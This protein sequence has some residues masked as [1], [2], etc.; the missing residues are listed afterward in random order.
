MHVCGGVQCLS[1]TVSLTPAAV[2]LHHA[3]DSRSWQHTNALITHTFACTRTGAGSVRA[4][5]AFVPTPRCLALLHLPLFDHETNLNSSENELYRKWF[6]VCSWCNYVN[7][8]IVKVN[9]ICWI[10]RWQSLDFLRL[11]CSL[12]RVIELTTSTTWSGLS[13]QRFHYQSLSIFTVRAACVMADRIWDRAAD[14]I[15]VMASI[16]KLCRPLNCAGAFRQIWV[17][18]PIS[19]V[20]SPP[21]HIRTQCQMRPNSP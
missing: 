13:H 16:F 5:D 9:W 10:I 15:P 8:S 21:G 2:R 19:G 17:I 14:I 11:R 3:T 6:N 7:L 18:R 12:H 20:F 1:V 4:A